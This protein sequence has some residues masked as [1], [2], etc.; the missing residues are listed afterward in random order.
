[1]LECRVL[2]KVK[3]GTVPMK[4]IEKVKRGTVPMKILCDVQKIFFIKSF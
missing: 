2:E 3:R 4:S 1:L